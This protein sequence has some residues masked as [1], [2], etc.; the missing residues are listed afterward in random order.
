MQD[1]AEPGVEGG[2][3]AD[4]SAADGC[5]DDVDREERRPDQAPHDKAGER[6][7]PRKSHRFLLVVS[8]GNIEKPKSQ[9]CDALAPEA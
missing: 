4:S 8:G 9:V 2:R 6:P 5:A 1:L 7:A 3:C